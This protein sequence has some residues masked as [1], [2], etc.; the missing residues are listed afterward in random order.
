VPAFLPVAWKLED[1]QSEHV[2]GKKSGFA[3]AL[4]RS[5]PST[6]DS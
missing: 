3:V 5:K 4:K 1:T 6:I 2:I